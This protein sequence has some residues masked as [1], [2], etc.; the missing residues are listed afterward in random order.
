MATFK[1]ADFTPEAISK[2]LTLLRNRLSEHVLEI[3]DLT[4]GV[5]RVEYLQ[6]AAQHFPVVIMGP[7][8]EVKPKWHGVERRGGKF[9][10]PFDGQGLIL[11]PVRVENGAWIFADVPQ[12]ER[13]VRAGNVPEI[14][15]APEKP[16]SSSELN[17]SGSDNRQRVFIPARNQGKTEAARSVLDSRKAT[18]DRR[19]DPPHV[20]GYV[21]PWRRIAVDFADRRGRVGPAAVGD[22]WPNPGRI[23]RVIRWRRWPNEWADRRPERRRTVF[24]MRTGHPDIALY[25]GG[26]RHQIRRA[27]DRGA[28]T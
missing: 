6:A 1:P 9:T 5:S 8:P 12:G 27:C 25:A 19:K 13:R 18:T 28:S 15:S 2:R 7:P 16:A 21:G 3:T 17:S 11:R 20:S 23:T 22:D 26:A 10:R 24:D 14:S 4:V